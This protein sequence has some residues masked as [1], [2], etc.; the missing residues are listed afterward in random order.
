MALASLRVYR[1][2][3]A[4]RW[5]EVVCGSYL[6]A[7]RRHGMYRCRFCLASILMTVWT[8]R[9]VTS[10]VRTL[11]A[12]ARTVLPR[13]VRAG[14]LEHAVHA[15]LDG[16]AVMPAGASGRVGRRHFSRRSW[17]DIGRTIA[18]NVL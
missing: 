12:G 3:I 18:A 17:F 10:G 16:Q 8:S 15:R 9:R 11:R 5:P 2:A 14:V 6:S 4:E 1:T 7:P 13:D